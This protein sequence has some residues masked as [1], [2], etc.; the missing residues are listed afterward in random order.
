MREGVSLL[1]LC[2]QGEDLGEIS[3]V[4][5]DL[6]CGK[7]SYAVLGAGGAFGIGEKYLAVP[8]TAFTPSADET[9]LVLQADK[10]GIARQK[11]S[12]TTG[13]PYRTPV[14]EQR[15]SGRNQINSINTR[16]GGNRIHRIKTDRNRICKTRGARAWNTES[17]DT[18]CRSNG[19]GVKTQ[20]EILLRDKGSASPFVLA[21]GRA[22]GN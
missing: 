6:Q 15:H 21:A 17:A 12:G 18:E 13:L 2:Q 10:N 22:T 20:S 5:I 11:A 9:H 16:T 14:L 3:D 19:V 1:N 7:V 8:L 4:V